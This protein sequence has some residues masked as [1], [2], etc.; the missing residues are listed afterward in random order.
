MLDA[1][2]YIILI[3]T[4]NTWANRINSLRQIAIIQ[5]KAKYIYKIYLHIYKANIFTIILCLFYL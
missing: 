4:E 3:L 2:E 1:H 5:Y